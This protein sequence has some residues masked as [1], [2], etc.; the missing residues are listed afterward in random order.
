[1]SESKFTPGPWEVRGRSVI[2]DTT[3]RGGPH[4]ITLFKNDRA[5]PA[6]GDLPNLILASCAPELL[7]AAEQGEELRRWICEQISKAIYESEELKNPDAFDALKGAMYDGT[8]ASYADAFMP[9]IT[10]AKGEPDA[11]S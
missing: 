7:V 10:K 9:A 4:K 3:A 6:D 11:A 1:M 2:A 8:L 5:Y